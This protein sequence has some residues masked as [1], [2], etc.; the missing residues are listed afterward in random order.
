M[1][2]TAPITIT[3]PHDMAAMVKENVASGKY[4]TESEVIRDGLRILKALDEMVEAWL[5]EE[6]AKS[7]DDFT[8]KPEAAIP[9]EEIMARLQQRTRARLAKREK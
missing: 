7:Y 6:V 5:R 4:A 3:L 2:T 1:R 9:A 8:A